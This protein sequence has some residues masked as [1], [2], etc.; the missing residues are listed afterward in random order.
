MAV[1]VV[2]LAPTVVALAPSIP[3]T[4]QPVTVP[5]WFETAADHLPAG[6]VLLTS[7]FA[8]AN[9]QAAIPWQAIGGMHY[10]MAGGGGPAG[11]PSRAGAYRAGFEVL[12]A[13]SVPLGPQPAPTP[14]NLLAVR[15]ALRGWGVTMVV[16]PGDRG[17]PTF[18]TG[19]GTSY[20]VAFFTAAL[21][22]APVRQDGAW[23]WPRASAS[24]PPVPISTS[25][26]D[27]CIAGGTGGAAA[28]SG[29]GRCVLASTPAVTGSEN[30][31]R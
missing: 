9:S 14:A 6:Q 27:A 18:Q 22:V 4:V 8:T 17:L 10:V 25:R 20:G 19:R 13:A 2:A 3:V 16:V 23:V 28:V 12:S 1:A 24:P 21:G 29:I 5:R 7:P 15:R 30:P 11:T 26:L 31:G